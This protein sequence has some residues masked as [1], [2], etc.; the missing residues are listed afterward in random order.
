MKTRFSRR[1]LLGVAAGVPALPLLP[2]KTQTGE[3][4]FASKE[5]AKI[6]P[7]NR[8]P[9]MVQEHF[10]AKVRE[11]ETDANEA[12]ARLTT[13]EE[14][15][16]YVASVRARIAACFGPLPDKTP[17]NPR[18]TGQLDRD[19]YR[20]EKVI[21]ESRPGMLVTANLYI[22]K[23]RSF[24]LP[25]V[26]GSCGHS[27]DGKA[28]ETYQSFA[29]GLARLGYVVLIFDPI[30]QGERLQYPD[31][32]GQSRIGIG[33]REHNYA[34]NQQ[35]L[36]GE[37]FAAWRTW[38]GIRALDYL[39]T[40]PE[41]DP[42]HVG[43]T[44]N[45]G[46]GTITTWLCGLERRWT[47]AAPGCF[48]TTFRRN[49]ENELPA[50]IE[51]CPPRV[52]AMGLDHSDF[53][54]AMAPKPIIVLA[55]ERDFFDARGA[56]E[57][58]ARL[59]RL[60]GLLGAED[61]IAFSIGPTYHGYSQESREA[62][63]GWFNK[64]TGISSQSQEPPLKLE[65]EKDLVCTP[66][67]QVA[68]LGSRPVFSFTQERSR[69]LAK[70]RVK[71]EDLRAAVISGLNLGQWPAAPDYRILRPLKARG[72]PKEFSTTYAVETEPGIQAIV[73]RLSD[74]V[75][76]SRPLPGKK[77]AI[78]YVAHQS[79]DVELR[80]ES[81]VSEL[82]A[83]EPDSDFYAC[84]VR[85]IGE[86]RPD[87]CGEQTF[88]DPYGSDYFY[89]VHSVML[90][91]PYLAG[92][93]L[94]LLTVLEWLHRVGY[95]EIH[96]AGKQWGSL[97]ATFAAVISDHVT[98]VTL[99]HTLPSYSAVAETEEYKW[100]LSALIPNVLNRFDLPDCY[101]ALARKGLR[102]IEG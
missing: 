32:A 38:D 84:D 67:G 17:L 77:R 23:N 92:K 49:L 5:T 8:F 101:A 10:V 70:S 35:L 36:V 25:G 86:S 24:P 39:L 11:V 73:Y 22:P 65:D 44:G 15:E 93:T 68:G 98:A 80:E 31:S 56:E 30:G 4:T 50:D 28:N 2:I 89:A 7:L 64:V 99:K 12:R 58:F 19:S 45:S 87:T 3:A 62:M 20:V 55:K 29:Q 72:Y 52:L 33:T 34:G 37:C 60:Y 100:P 90:G 53:L 97:P 1:T 18:V 83:A 96:L 75:H 21:F 95:S 102:Q 43:I 13:R 71:P 51:Q 82:I 85:G 27:N 74:E 59:K 40:R 66:N 61:R 63:Y 26:V 42:K 14:A 91:R 54:A 46:G 41:V 16:G 78:L 88:L 69:Q 48:V 94:D 81:L 57:A 47:M 9:R 79:S 76:Y 6:E